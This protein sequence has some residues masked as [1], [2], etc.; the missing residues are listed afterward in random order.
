MSYTSSSLDIFT[1][2]SKF[3]KIMD[4]ILVTVASYFLC[5]IFTIYV[6]QSNTLISK[7]GCLIISISITLVFIK[8]ANKHYDKLKIKQEDRKIFENAIN[9]LAIM[10]QKEIVNFF[11]KTLPERW[12]P[13][14]KLGSLTLNNDTEVLINFRDDTINKTIF[15]HLFNSSKHVN[16]RK[17]YVFCN[18]FENNVIHFAENIKDKKFTF[19][20]AKQVFEII[21]KTNQFPPTLLNSRDTHKRLDIK[22]IFDKS[23]IKKYL[24]AGLGIYLISFFTFSNRIYYSI[25]ASMCFIIALISIFY[26]QRE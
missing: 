18:N 6:I 22:S 13:Q 8:L 16:Y 9:S 5:R 25:M 23:K 15:L 7:I 10:P 26:N 14:I 11:K 1:C 24:L 19:F 21:K 20:N 2:K 4:A 12:K 17:F 3:S